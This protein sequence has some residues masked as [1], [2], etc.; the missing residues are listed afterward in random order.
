MTDAA[1]SATRP[2]V[3]RSPSGPEV[4]GRRLLAES[5]GFGRALRTAHLPVDL[6]AAIDFARALTLVDLGEREQVRAAGEAIFTRRRDDREIYDAV[7][8]RWWRRRGRDLPGESDGTLPRAEDARGR[9]GAADGAARPETSG[10]TARPR[11]DGV[12]MPSSDGDDDERRRSTASSRPRRVQPRR[13]P[14]PPRL[15]P[16]DARRAARRRAPRRPPGRG[17]S[18][19]G[20]AVTSSTST[21]VGS[22]R[23]RCSGGTSQK[24]R[25]G[26][27]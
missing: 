25:S 15:R 21:A 7:F 17:W 20:P 12:P 10:R 9:R 19:A 18:G 26:W 24:A 27:R 1:R 5:V 6:G 14:P 22:R 13:A 16:D 8:D 3:F 4:D 2:A 11:R 23:G